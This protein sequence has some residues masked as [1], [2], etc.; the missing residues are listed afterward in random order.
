MAKTV[1][2]AV[3]G[4]AELKDFVA[5]RGGLAT[6]IRLWRLGFGHQNIVNRLI[7]TAGVGGF[8]VVEGD[9]GV[10]AARVS[11]FRFFYI[12]GFLFLN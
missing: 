12:F 9:D 2:L 4:V 11:K 7:A 3:I 5:S 6:G 10:V 1:R 8:R